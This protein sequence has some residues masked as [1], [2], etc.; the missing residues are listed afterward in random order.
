M[1]HDSGITDEEYD[2]MTCTVDVFG[3]LEELAE[4]YRTTGMEE[5]AKQLLN[6][7]STRHEG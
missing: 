7:S 1:P 5:F 2:G 3:G 4:A 6:D